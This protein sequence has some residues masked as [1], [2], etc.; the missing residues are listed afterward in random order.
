MTAFILYLAEIKAKI[1]VKE[2]L[3][4]VVDC[5]FRGCG[6][7]R[8]AVVVMLVV[9]MVVMVVM[10]MVAGRE[11]GREGSLPRERGAAHPITERLSINW[12]FNAAQ[13][14][15]RQLDATPNEEWVFATLTRGRRTLK[16]SWI[17]TFRNDKD[18]TLLP[19]FF[20]GGVGGVA[21]GARCVWGSWWYGGLVW[22]AEW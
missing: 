5:V 13:Q 22:T 3:E 8:A 11:T 17:L 6:D 14:T 18:I 20:P 21:G 9:V 16:W 1:T 12:S 7:G 15:R 4:S 19:Q 2:T 10:V